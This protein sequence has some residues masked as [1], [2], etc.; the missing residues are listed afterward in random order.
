MNSMH[1]GLFAGIML[2]V[3]IVLSVIILFI[4][5]KITKGW[6]ERKQNVYEGKK[7]KK[8]LGHS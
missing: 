5:K 4:K 6:N 1:T 7:K 2:L 8:E 3:A